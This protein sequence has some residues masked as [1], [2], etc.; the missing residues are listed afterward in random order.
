[1][2][3]LAIQ[4]LI[5]W[6]AL[7]SA[8]WVADLAGAGAVYK[9]VDEHGKVHYG[10]R[11]LPGAQTVRLRDVPE[12]TP[13]P[14]ER[15]EKRKRL[16][17]VLEEQRQEK[18]EAVEA[19]KKLKQERERNCNLARDRLRNYEQAGYI[20]E[21]DQKGNRV[22]YDEGKQAAAVQAARDTVKQ[23]CGKV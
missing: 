9:W 11:P 22:I 15:E 19:Q 1:M 14:G 2:H 21:I 23:W 13:M 16:L 10:D 18:R 20:Y 12:V 5:S 7:V 3:G 8:L 17:Q 4:I 6:V